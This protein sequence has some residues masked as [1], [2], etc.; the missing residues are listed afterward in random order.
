VPWL[1]F[2]PGVRKTLA[3]ERSLGERYTID[4]V[5]Y[6]DDVSRVAPDESGEHK[7]EKRSFCVSRGTKN[8]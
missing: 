5:A 2:I 7:E 1:Q 3:A 6:L 8:D 4:T